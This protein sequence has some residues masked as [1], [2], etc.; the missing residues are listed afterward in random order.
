MQFIT[1]DVIVYKGCVFEYLT[2]QWNNINLGLQ[3][4]DLKNFH[5]TTQCL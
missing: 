2:I 4:L 1:N 3:D 5:Q